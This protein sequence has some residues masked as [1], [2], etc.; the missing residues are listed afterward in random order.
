MTSNPAYDDHLAVS[1]SARSK[2]LMCMRGMIGLSRRAFCEK[3][4]LS[5]GTLQNWE[6]ARFGGLTEKGAKRMIEH[7]K[8]EGVYCSFRWLMYGEGEEAKLVDHAN[9]G[10]DQLIVRRSSLQ[11]D[12]NAMSAFHPDA[13]TMGVIDDSMIP[14]LTKGSYVMGKK[15]YGDDIKR[16]TNQVCVVETK[17]GVRY[18]RLLRASHKDGLYNLYV[19]NPLTKVYPSTIIN[20]EVSMAAP[21][22][23]IRKPS[24]ISLNE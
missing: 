18:I 1:K 14:I 16:C 19:Y 20:T 2:R 9:Q 5:P 10:S 7:F 13:V 22:F 3:Y 24:T 15:Q 17:E 4:N 21:I 23:W 8:E 6:K 11:S 12:I